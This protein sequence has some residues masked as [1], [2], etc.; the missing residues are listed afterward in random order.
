MLGSS[1]IA[2]ALGGAYVS[3]P[4]LVKDMFETIL[5]P[6]ARSRLQSSSEE[7]NFTV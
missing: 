1:A 2:E 5:G 6:D 7:K 3:M 4:V